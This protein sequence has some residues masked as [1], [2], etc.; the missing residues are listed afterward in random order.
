MARQLMRKVARLQA[1]HRIFCF[2]QKKAVKCFL[3]FFYVVGGVSSYL[4]FTLYLERVPR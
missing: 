2:V 3:E 1:H 4:L